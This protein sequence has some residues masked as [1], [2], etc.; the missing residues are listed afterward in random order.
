[1]LI[2]HAVRCAIEARTAST[3][4]IIYPGTKIFDQ[5]IPSITIN[6]LTTIDNGPYP[7]SWSGFVYAWA[8]N[9]TKIIG[10]HTMKFGVFIER[11]GQNDHIQFTTASAPATINE[12]GSFRFL[13]TGRTDATGSQ[14]AIRCS[15]YSMIT[16]NWA[17][18]P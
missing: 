14:S 16:R 12:N 1:M 17:A 2:R 11:S 3:I 8:N 5:K 7:G 15:D 9:T 18:S 4:R 6:G 13:D 10:N